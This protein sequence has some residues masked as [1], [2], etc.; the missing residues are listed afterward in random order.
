M[1]HEVIEEHEK[2][3]ETYLEAGDFVKIFHKRTNCVISVTSQEIAP[4]LIA[5][6][7]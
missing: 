7:F 4:A 6:Y 3:N 2:F 5:K 1:S